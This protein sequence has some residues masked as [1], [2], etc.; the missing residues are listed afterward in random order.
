MKKIVLFVMSALFVVLVV[1]SYQAAGIVIAMAEPQVDYFNGVAFTTYR[2]PFGTSVAN[3]AEN[4]IRGVAM[5]IPLFSFIL[6]II[7]LEISSLKNTKQ[8]I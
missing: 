3:L 1:V 6:G 7:I 4:E 8:Y 2:V 5:G